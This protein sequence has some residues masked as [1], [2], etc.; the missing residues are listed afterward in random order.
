MLNRK[1]KGN[2]QQGQNTLDVSISDDCYPKELRAKFE[3]GPN[4]KFGPWALD[5]VRI[6][7]M[8]A[9]VDPDPPITVALSLP[10]LDFAGPLIAAGFIAKR[11]QQELC[12][13]DIADLSS[14]DRSQLF[15]QLC[16]LPHGTPLFLRISSGKMVYA[17]FER[18]EM[19]HGQRWA[20]IRYQGESKGAL[21]QYINENNV[22]SVFFTIGINDK[23]TEARIGSRVNVRLGLARAFV[24]NTLVLRQLILRSSA[25]CALIGV[26]QT[27]SREL[28]KAEISAR[29]YDDMLAVGTLQDIVR[30]RALIQPEE[31]S[32]TELFTAKSKAQNISQYNPALAIYCGS[33][34]YVT[35]AERIPK[36]HHVAL[37]NPV[38]RNFDVGVAALNNAFLN[39]LSEKI[40]IDWPIPKGAV[41]MIFQRRYS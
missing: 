2:T 17:V 32:R 13:S 22:D 33:T 7:S 24:P 34:A 20:V 21:S 35:Q 23:T 31:A 36:A 5:L 19:V 27:L 8:L 1:E 6:G 25:D 37:L 40:D 39:K 14:S 29:V 10:T 41:A 16:L 15:R 18:V 28:S 38:E 30:V 26:I 4:K 3:D 12:N 9:R 11:V